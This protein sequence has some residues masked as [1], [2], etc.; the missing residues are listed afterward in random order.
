MTDE[1]RPAES[2]WPQDDRPVWERIVE[3][4]E[5]LPPEVFDSI[6]SPDAPPSE[7]VRQPATKRERALAEQWEMAAMSEGG[8]TYLGCD[9]EYYPTEHSQPW[10]LQQHNGA[11]GDFATFIDALA[12]AEQLAG[13]HE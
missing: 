5:S 2:G 12:H 13:D 8:I 9:I 7:I 11:K 10:L 1:Q 6:P 3:M 4:A